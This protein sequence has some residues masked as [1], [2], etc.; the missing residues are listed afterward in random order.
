MAQKHLRHRQPPDPV[1]PG[2]RD[3]PR[4]SHLQLHRHPTTDI[5]YAMD[6]LLIFD[7][8]RHTDFIS[9]DNYLIKTLERVRKDFTEKLFEKLMYCNFSILFHYI[10]E[11][12]YYSSFSYSL[13]F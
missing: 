2:S 4:F 6:F 13:F 11:E 12:S 5:G 8:I 9:A 1:P 3:A 7:Y 10:I